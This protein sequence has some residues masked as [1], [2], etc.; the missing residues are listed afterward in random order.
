M[1]VAAQELQKSGVLPLTTVEYAP[2]PTIASPRSYSDATVLV[3]FRMKAACFRPHY[4][5][6]QGSFL[7]LPLLLS[8]LK[9]GIDFDQQRTRLT[10]LRPLCKTDASQQLFLLLESVGH[11]LDAFWK[12][13]GTI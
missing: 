5:F 13:L 4:M 8:Y 1:E 7:P 12:R 2:S 6:H 11:I 3:F 9:D 10:K